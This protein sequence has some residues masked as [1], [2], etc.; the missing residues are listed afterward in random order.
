MNFLFVLLLRGM[1]F[2]QN[3]NV[4]QNQKIEKRVFTISIFDFNFDFSN[5]HNALRR[6]S[7]FG[8]YKNIINTFR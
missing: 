8:G 7:L 5:F 6:T 3:Q 1:F 2:N 4:N